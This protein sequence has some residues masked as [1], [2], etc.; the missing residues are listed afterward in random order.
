MTPTISVVVVVGREGEE[1]G[2]ERGSEVCRWDLL[3]GRFIS[4]VINIK[5]FMLQKPSI[6]QTFFIHFFVYHCLPQKYL[7]GLS[8]GF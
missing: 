3:H 2:E 5:I 1:R 7:L 4:A 6:Q 8:R